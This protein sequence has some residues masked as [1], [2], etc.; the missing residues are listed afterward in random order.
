MLSL[1]EHST[2]LFF[3]KHVLNAYVKDMQAAQRRDSFPNMVMEDLLFRY[4][5]VITC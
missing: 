5:I 4:L 2:Q 3:F 1:H